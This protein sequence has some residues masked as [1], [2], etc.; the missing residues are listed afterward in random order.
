MAPDFAEFRAVTPRCEPRGG[1]C[2][3]RRRH[4]T[5]VFL[6]RPAGPGAPG[7]ATPGR[8]TRAGA[9]LRRSKGWTSV[10][11]NGV[12]GGR[13]RLRP[14]AAPAA[15]GG[16]SPREARGPRP[17][18]RAERSG[19]RA[20]GRRGT[21]AGAGRLSGSHAR[22]P[23]PGLPRAAHGPQ[24]SP[25]PRGPTHGSRRR[26]PPRCLRSR[27]APRCGQRAGAW[28]RGAP[29]ALAAGGRTSTENPAEG[30]ARGCTR[31]GGPCHAGLPTHGETEAR[32]R[33][34]NTRGARRS[35]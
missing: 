16:A 34:G 21:G 18:M 31:R 2:G 20:P 8:A 5:P 24:G 28:R 22:F 35:A 4:Q 25:R 6:S 15:A 26:A 29:R 23:S 27:S 19:A 12:A 1:T 32:R 17:G 11:L 30:S 13:T 33:E 14:P 10:P 3:L 9:E 7:R